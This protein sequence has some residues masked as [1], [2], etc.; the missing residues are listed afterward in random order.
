[1]YTSEPLKALGTEKPGI[2]EPQSQDPG[3]PAPRAP[4]SESMKSRTATEYQGRRVLELHAK[5][6]AV[7]VFS[8]QLLHGHCLHLTVIY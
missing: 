8:T 7:H 6:L 4:E 2:R 3:F 5:G 1:M